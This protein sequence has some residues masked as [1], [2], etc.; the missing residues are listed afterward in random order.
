MDRSD[1]ILEFLKEI[2]KFKYI[3]RKVYSSDLRPENDAEH[4]WH[5][6]MFLILFEKDLP[7]G[8]DMAKMLKLAL[9]HDLVEIYAGDVST[10]DKE[11]RQGKK[12]REVKAAKKLFLQLPKDLEGDFTKLFEEYEEQKTP[13]AKMVKAFDKIQPLLL[14]I[15]SKGESWKRHDVSIED[16]HKVKKKFVEHDE[17]LL[18]LYNKLL[19]EARDKGL[20]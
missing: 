17:L 9:M 16:I 7:E 5:L 2:E 12:E 8:L 18:S 1:K 4:S 20:I 15:C 10:F 3:E 19:D 11:G 6:A 14:N 13:E